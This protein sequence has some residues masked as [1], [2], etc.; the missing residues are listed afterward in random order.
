MP[1][2]LWV[3]VGLHINTNDDVKTSKFYVYMAKYSYM[4]LIPI[5]RYNS[6]WRGN[7]HT[8]GA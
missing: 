8:K 3:Q 6:R 7:Y 2:I 1:V 5:I 4:I